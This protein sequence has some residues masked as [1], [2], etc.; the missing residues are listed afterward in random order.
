MFKPKLYYS[1]KYGF[2]FNDYNDYMRKY[3]KAKLVK[4]RNYICKYQRPPP[5]NVKYMNITICFS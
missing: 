1:N 4:Q 2:K 5:L 3:N